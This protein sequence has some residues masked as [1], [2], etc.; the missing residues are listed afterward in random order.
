[1]KN[2]ALFKH[3]SRYQ[4][5]LLCFTQEPSQLG[6]SIFPNFPKQLKISQKNVS[7]FIGSPLHRFHLALR[8]PRPEPSGELAVLLEVDGVLMDAY[9]LG[10]R[11]TFNVAFK[12]LG[13]DCAN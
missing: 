7:T 1:M 2:S 11:Q 8:R 3:H 10:N 6:S 5:S 12:K 9:R 4:L 13:L